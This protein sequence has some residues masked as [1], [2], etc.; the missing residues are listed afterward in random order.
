M[1]YERRKKIVTPADG[2]FCLYRFKE[3]VITG[4]LPHEL[5][6]AL[7]SM[8]TIRQGS[9]SFEDQFEL[10]DAYNAE[11]KLYGFM[12]RFRLGFLLFGFVIEAIDRHGERYEGYAFRPPFSF[13]K[14]LNQELA[15]RVAM[16]GRK[17]AA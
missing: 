12:C 7:G 17:K 8:T 10:A 2:V 13:D 15:E 3:Q 14:F 5:M 4:D 1:F 11:D 9:R 16:A 6:Q